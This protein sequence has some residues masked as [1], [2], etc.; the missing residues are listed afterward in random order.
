ME[1]HWQTEDG[2]IRL[3]CADCLDVLPTLSGVDAVVT[4]PPYPEEFVPLYAPAW[5]QCDC[6]LVD[7]GRVFAMCGQAFLPRVVASFPAHWIYVW[8]GCFDCAHMATSI[9]PRG[10]SAAWKPLFIYQKP[11]FRSF[12]HWKYDTISLGKSRYKAP[13][14]FHEWGQGTF[15]FET[16]L[17]RFDVA[18]TVLDPFMGSGTTGVACVR[19]GRRFIG[20]EKEPR[21]FEIAKTR[22]QSELEKMRLFEPPPRIVQRSLLDKE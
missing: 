7:G 4:D 12:K 5:E 20:I 16:V 10:I 14:E 21:Y 8:T 3:Y 17:S 1:P 2:S 9:W 15:E 6:A 13:K 11:P 22:I 19:L 18:G